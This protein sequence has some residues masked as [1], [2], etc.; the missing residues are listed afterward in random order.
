MKKKINI[1]PIITI[2]LLSVTSV[3]GILSMDFSKGY[4]VTNHRFQLVQIFAFYWF[5]FH[6][7]YIR[8]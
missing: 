6:Y 8:I 2:L 7:L 5:W 4:E 1:L 3:A